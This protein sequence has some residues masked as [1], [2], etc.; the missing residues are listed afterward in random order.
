M[1][2]GGQ[3]GSGCEADVCVTCSVLPE[4][5]A[6]EGQLLSQAGLCACP[7]RAV[8]SS[9]RASL[10]E[11]QGLDFPGGEA[12]AGQSQ[13]PQLFPSEHQGARQVR[14][15]SVCCPVRGVTRRS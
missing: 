5:G 13:S 8:L 10:A 2:L 3:E 15:L 11:A 7:S 1:G 9:P 6:R 12:R 4:P 14:M